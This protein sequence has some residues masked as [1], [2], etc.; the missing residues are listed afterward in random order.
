MENYREALVPVFHLYGEKQF[1]PTPDLLHCESIAARSRLHDWYIKPHRHKDLLHILEVRS[2]EVV[3]ELDGEEFS[4]D[5]PILFVIPSMAIHGFRFSRDVEG[6]VITLAKP[7][8]DAYSERFGFNSSLW[9]EVSMIPTHSVGIETS[10]VRMVEREYATPAPERDACLQGLVQA[11][12]VFI[13]RK[14]LRL[15]G[16]NR[17]IQGRTTDQAEVLFQQYQDAVNTQFTTQPTVNELASQLGTT[18]ARLNTVCRKL[19]NK[20]ALQVLH[21]RIVLQA[22]RELTYT[23]MTISQVSDSLGFSEAPYFTRFFKRETG[24]TPKK[25]RSRHP[26]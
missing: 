18:S 24:M 19:V 20:S 21:E 6:T 17:G 3:L 26:K 10:M 12:A 11:L 8:I 7:M 25:F 9:S 23:S 1:W 22:K 5:Q 14:K 15:R 13:L 4:F 16:A 2:G